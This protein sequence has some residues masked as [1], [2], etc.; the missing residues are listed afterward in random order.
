MTKYVEL[1]SVNL[2]I[3]ACVAMGDGPVDLVNVDES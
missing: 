3:D 1:G 2:E